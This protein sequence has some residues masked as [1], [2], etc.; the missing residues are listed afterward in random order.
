MNRN[1]EYEALLRELEMSPAR[2]EY[3]VQ[4]AEAKVKRSRRVRKFFGIPAGSLAAFFVS[5]TLLVNLLPTFAHACSGIPVLRELAKVVAWS[6]SL[7]AA[8]ENEYVQPIE[9]EQTQNGITARVEYVIVDRKQLNVFFT[10]QSRQY[11]QLETEASVETPDGAGGFSLSNGSFGTP[12][13]ELRQVSL[14]FMERDM[15]DSLRLTLDIYDA[16]A[17]LD[18]HEAPAQN[19]DDAWFDDTEP[20][21]PKTLASFT[22]DLSFD[23]EFTARGE[24]VTVN[25][26]FLLDGQTVTVTEAEIYPTHLRV[27]FAYDDANTAWLRGL[28]FYLENERGQRFEPV[29]NGITAT[30]AVD[31]PAMGSFWLD[32]TYF[33]HSSH[34][35]LHITQSEW[36]DKD[37]QRIR[38]NLLTGESDAMPDGVSFVQAE[39]RKAGWLLTFSCTMF[40]EGHHYSPWSHTFYDEAGNEFEGNGVSSS[41]SYQDAETGEW[42]Y[43]EDESLFYSEIPLPNYQADIVWLSPNFTRM[44]ESDNVVSVPIR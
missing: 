17:G 3:S 43:C 21:Q 39:R 10:L 34:L 42:I 16:G 28:D 6:P 4:R 31:S 13:G 44:V 20:N 33:S 8:V 7:S 41:S 29:T 22:F 12:N 32:S 26:T 35:T 9:Q 40:E 19:V 15:T 36:L 5:F 25:Q 1:A 11:E 37:R 30:G 38:L 23:P 2:L 18:S 14:D 24:T 27:N